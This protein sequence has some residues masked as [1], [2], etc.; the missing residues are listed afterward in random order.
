MVFQSDVDEGRGMVEDTLPGSSPQW[1]YFISNEQVL[2]RGIAI[3][4]N[5]RFDHKRAI[6]LAEKLI[7]NKSKLER[8]VRRVLG[9][10]GAQDISG[11][12]AATIHDYSKVI[13]TLPTFAFVVSDRRYELGLSCTV[14]QGDTNSKIWVKVTR[15]EDEAQIADQLADEVVGET[16][17]FYASCAKE[18]DAKAKFESKFTFNIVGAYSSDYAI[19]DVASVLSEPIDADSKF[20][21]LRDRDKLSSVARLFQ[22]A[23]IE[24]DAFSL[25]DDALAET[26]SANN[27][28]DA[29]FRAAIVPV[30]VKQ[31]EAIVLMRADKGKSM[32]DAWGLCHIDSLDLHA[33]PPVYDSASQLT[34]KLA[35]LLAA[36]V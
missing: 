16:F 21:Q 28:S 10:N 30:A 20:N 3:S 2:R 22:Y 31:S 26:W 19:P 17:K 36:D 1:N 9:K 8:A 12:T 27:H 5:V 24:K 18:I 4:S 34:G 25:S 32:L 29:G 7:E 15:Y 6:A 23:S 33:E 14:C 11:G 35:S 13:V